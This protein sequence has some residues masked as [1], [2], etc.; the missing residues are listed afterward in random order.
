MPEPMKSQA[1]ARPGLRLHDA[2]NAATA[3]IDDLRYPGDRVAHAEALP[4]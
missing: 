3:H 4:H 1:A 2:L